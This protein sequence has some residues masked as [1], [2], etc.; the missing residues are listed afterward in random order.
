MAIA[1]LGQIVGSAI[2]V[3]NAD[4]CRN[5]KGLVTT[6]SIKAFILCRYLEVELNQREANIIHFMIC[7]FFSFALMIICC[8]KPQKC[9][10]SHNKYVLS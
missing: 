5:R 4:Q 10:P 7:V 3:F 6:Y 2:G 1:Q 9:T 8:S